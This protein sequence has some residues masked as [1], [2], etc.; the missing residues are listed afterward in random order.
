MPHHG[1]DATRAGGDGLQIMLEDLQDILAEHDREVI[2]L[3]VK[4]ERRVALRTAA[5][6][7]A[8]RK[9]RALRAEVEEQR[10][11]LRRCLSCPDA[12]LCA[13]A[14]RPPAEIGTERLRP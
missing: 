5:L 12:P 9:L 1:G 2:A 14:R 3:A 4:L 6:R 7:R 8:R 10:R 11:T 13:T